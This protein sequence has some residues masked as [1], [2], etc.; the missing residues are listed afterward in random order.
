MWGRRGKDPQTTERDVTSCVPGRAKPWEA[1]R[2]TLPPRTHES[3]HHR[4]ELKVKSDK[5]ISQQTTE[6]SQAFV[7]LWLVLK[8]M[9][10]SSLGT[11]KLQC[12]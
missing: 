2:H 11:N 4:G 3:I 10:F 12:E 9:S 5:R 8:E 1:S 7:K 6:K